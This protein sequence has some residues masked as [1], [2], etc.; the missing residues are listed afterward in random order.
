MTATT[1]ELLTAL[2]S[3]ASDR[4][5]IIAEL[6]DRGIWDEVTTLTDAERAD[7]IADQF[8]GEDMIAR[9]HP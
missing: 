6:R 9:H 2:A 5:A 4:A 3:Q 1:N 7:H 8:T